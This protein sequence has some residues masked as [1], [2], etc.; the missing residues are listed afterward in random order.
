MKAWDE[1]GELQALAA[2][3]KDI[4]AHLSKE[5]IDRVFSLDTYLRNVDAIFR[6]VF[7]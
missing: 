7:G 1:G 5:Q 4:S 2:G 3:D 6:R